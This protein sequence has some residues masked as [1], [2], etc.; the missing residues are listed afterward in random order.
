MLIIPREGEIITSSQL[1]G[2]ARVRSARP[3]G[4]GVRIEAVALETDRYFDRYFD[5]DE[6]IVQCPTFDTDG[7]RFRLAALAEY[8]RFTSD[9]QTQFAVG[10][11]LIDPLPHQIDAVYN[12]L[13]PSSPIRFLLA[14]DPGAGKTIMAGLLFKE[15]QRRGA[16]ERTLI[17]VPANLRE[18]WRAE[19]D[20]KF[21]ERFTVLESKDAH[22]AV[23]PDF[24]REH[25]CAIISVDLAKRD[26]WQQSLSLSKWDLVIVD[27]A[28]KMAAYKYGAKIE[29][30]KAYRLGEM[31][32]ANTNHLLLLTA[33]PHR[34]RSDN[35]RMLLQ[36]LDAD[37]FQTDEN[38]RALSEQK[39]IPLVLRRLKEHLHTFD[40][41]PLYKKR[42]VRSVGGR[43][44]VE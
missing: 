1:P 30:T 22:A 25:P 13:L 33:T 41:Q 5:A 37:L 28:H 38:V 36:L 7:E 12:Y 10:A 8:F 18:Q 43:G 2:S 32:G 24:W 17:V 40:G 39:A 3:E 23:N 9:S 42:T 11:S 16:L 31:L 44:T 19:L 29:R 20:T 26:N 15:M 4:A 27:E 21:K 14:D 34:E 35:Y 6:F